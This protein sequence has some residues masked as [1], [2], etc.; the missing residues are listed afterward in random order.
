MAPIER[1][2]AFARFGATR[3]LE[4]A[5]CLE[6]N[7]KVSWPDHELSRLA[8]YLFAASL[9]AESGKTFFVALF[10]NETPRYQVIVYRALV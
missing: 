6:V 10:L 2:S 7:P 1:R 5:D 8:E 9:F 3:R 4:Q